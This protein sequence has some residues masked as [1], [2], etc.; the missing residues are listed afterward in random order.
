MA[1]F[2]GFGGGM[3]M[4]KLMKQAQKMQKDMEKAQEELKSK[5]VE[6][7]SGGGMVKISI[8]GDYEIK[9]VKIEKD[10]VDPDDVEMLQDLV[11]AALNDAVNKVKETSNSEMSKLTGG[12]KIPGLF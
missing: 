1:K 2:G 6:G 11:A 9:E 5:I 8:N 12:M 4:N 7:T 3:D 10:V